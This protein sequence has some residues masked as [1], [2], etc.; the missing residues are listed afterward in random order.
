MSAIPGELTRIEAGNS[1][2]SGLKP[3]WR[4]LFPSI[5]Q[6]LSYRPLQDHNGKRLVA[7]P[8]DVCDRGASMWRNTLV[9]QFIGRAPNFS[10]F[11]KLSCLLWGE[12][13][14]IFPAC[15]GLFL[16]Q[17]LNAKE[18][19]KVLEE[20]PRHIQNQPIILHK[21]EK[22]LEGLAFDMLKI[23]VW[24]HLGNV[25]LEL[26]NQEGLSYISSAIEDPLYMD[27]ITANHKR[28]AYAKVCVEVEAERANPDQI[29]VLMP[30]G[31]L[32]VVT[33][34]TPWL[35]AKC[36]LCKV[37]GHTER[38]CDKKTSDKGKQVLH[39]GTKAA[40]V[41]RFAILMEAVEKQDDSSQALE[42]KVSQEMIQEEC[43]V[44]R[45]MEYIVSQSLTQGD[46]NS[47]DGINETT[48]DIE[49]E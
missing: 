44:L 4:G 49:V 26:F 20:G 12:S 3:N 7:P 43:N 9:A 21:W 8:V 17:F 31:K 5:D 14:E 6:T 47:D 16:I 23:P 39:S 32:V 33:M 10:Y 38:F 42:P 18:R 29:E 24:I 13:V 19:D 28:F 48:N 30:D 37:F 34:E 22:G 41:N 1:S 40:S 15:N 45:E 25:P 36:S 35:H 27:R 2:N 11:Q 46:F